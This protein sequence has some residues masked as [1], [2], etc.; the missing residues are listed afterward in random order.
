M[1]TELKFVQGSVAKKDFLPALTHFVIENGSVRGY[2]GTLA[3]SS[4]IPFDIAC[5]PKA[6]E[7]VRAVMDCD[8][9]L[10]VALTLTSAGKLQI[11][12]GK[13]KRLVPCA[14]GETPHVL[15]SGETRALD[16]VALLTALKAVARFIGKDAARPWC[17]GALLRG[18]SVF[19]TNNVV[20]VEYWAGEVLPGV[21]NIP[22]AAVNE[23]LRLDEPPTHVQMDEHSVTFHFS[24][25][26][27]LRTNLLSTEWPDLTKVLG[28]P[29][30]PSPIDPTIF[31]AL[32]KIKHST[33]K[34]NRV[35]FRPGMLCTH[36][37][38]DGAS[39]DV[40]GLDVP[41]AYNLEML[42]LLEGAA[43]A[44]DFTTYPRPCMWRGER[45]RG[46]IVG[47]RT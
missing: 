30:N 8:P 4:P 10:P 13:F 27:W 29:C 42:A 15:P 12:N 39:Y 37:G 41:G 11:K 40:E 28:L 43:T 33:D 14:D 36:D 7:L 18:G 32:R 34:L 26:R 6:A 19:A 5:K 22:Q 21:V 3:I 38:E 16:G 17:N 9:E 23:L 25:N 45:L 24:G 46:A 2:N 44:I 35:L 20:L 31:E 1:L 47:L